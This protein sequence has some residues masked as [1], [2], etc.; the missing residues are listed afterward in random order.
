[1]NRLLTY[2]SLIL[3]MLGSPLMLSAQATPNEEQAQFIWLMLSAVF[4]IALACLVLTATVF[5][6]IK[7][8][9][10][11]A[12]ATATEAEGVEAEVATQ[13]PWFAWSRIRASLWDIVPVKE[14]SSIDMGHDYDGIRELDNNLPPW[15]K[16]G[17]YISIAYAVVYMFYFHFSGSDWSSDQEYQQEMAA[18]EAAKAER[19]E[20]VANLVDENSVSLVTEASALANGKQIYTTLC[21]ACHGPSGEGGVGPNLTDEYWI[22][23]GSVNDIFRTI[24]YGVPQ[25]GMISWQAQINPKDMQDV[26]SFIYQMQ[27]TNP[28]NGKAPE[29]EVYQ[30]KE[31]APSDSLSQDLALLNQP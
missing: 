29:G 14:E 21:V 4:V 5:F 9:K 11:P 20:K 31:E 7:A 13:E 6:M 18:A 26:S 8:Q 19:L 12:T 28:P 17:F 22:H 3:L 23:G 1:M 2:T 24:K 30:R 10:A 15:W 16:W 25:K 27:G